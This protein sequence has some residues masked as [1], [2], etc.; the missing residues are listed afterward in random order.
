MEALYLVLAVVL[1]LV[2]ELIHHQERVSWRNSNDQLQKHLI[3]LTDRAAL[4]T[5]DAIDHPT[6]GKVSYMDEAAE[7]LRQ[8]NATS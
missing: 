5:V 3:A 1:V 6:S 4:S 8:E 7:Y 2:Q